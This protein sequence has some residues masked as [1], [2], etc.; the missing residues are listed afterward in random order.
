MPFFGGSQKGQNTIYGGLFGKKVG[1]QKRDQKM[2]L[3]Y[4]FLEDPPKKASIDC[5]F[6]NEAQNSY[7]GWALFDPFLDWLFYRMY[8]Y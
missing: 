6:G 8:C 4:H 2:S 5:H 3:F 1:V 7:F